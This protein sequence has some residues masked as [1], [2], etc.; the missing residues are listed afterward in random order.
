M[1]R[2][3]MAGFEPGHTGVFSAT[4]VNGGGASLV[5]SAVD[6]RTGARC[7]A[8][9]L[10]GNNARAIGQVTLGAAIAEI[11]FR[12][13]LWLGVLPTGGADRPLVV[14][15]IYDNLGTLHLW[16]GVSSTGLLQV[17]RGPSGTYGSVVPGALLASGSTL[18]T[19]QYYQIEVRATIADA[20][21]I[22][23]VR[24]DGLLDIDFLGDTRNAG[25]ANVLRVDL[26]AQFP[27]LGA[28][29]FA[30]T[31]R[32]DDCV[33]NDT[34]GA[35]QNAWPGNTG[36]YGLVATGPG[37]YTQ[38]TPTAPPNWAAVDEV[39]PNDA[40]YVADSVVDRRDSYAM[41]NLPVSG[42]VVA[43]NWIARAFQDLAGAANI[44]RLYRIAGADY[45]GADMAIAIPVA[46]YQEVRETSPASGAAWTTSEID[47]MEVGVVVR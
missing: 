21:G 39:P 45:Q 18:A 16:V 41:G 5:V 40:D 26:G 13:Y 2:L 7:L 17:R 31:A 34:A 27:N 6:P 14:A 22:C 30:G 23:Q 46:Y 20:G 8:S 4:Q 9:T 33:I 28:A 42:D 29:G 44:A 15:A 32:Y 1:T 38:L 10:A 12:F 24:L 47:N 3:W 37:N 11:Y 36:I 35:T 25:N 43:V 19:G